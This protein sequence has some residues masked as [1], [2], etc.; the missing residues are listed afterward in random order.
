VGVG[1]KLPTFCSPTSTLTSLEMTECH[2]LNSSDLKDLIGWCAS[3]VYHIVCL[4]VCVRVCVC[5][6]LCVCVCVFIHEGVCKVCEC[7]HECEC[8]YSLAVYSDSMSEC[9]CPM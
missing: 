3:S 8:E 6:C 4:C 7:V 5:V 1:N 2:F 9:V